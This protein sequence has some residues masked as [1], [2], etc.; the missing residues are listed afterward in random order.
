MIRQAIQYSSIVNIFGDDGTQI[1]S[2]T[3]GSG[4][5][6]GYSRDFL[7]IR[8]GDMIVTKDAN[9]HQLGSLVIDRRYQIM[10]INESGF[11]ARD[12]SA[13]EV[14]DKYC[15]HQYHTSV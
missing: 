4:E 8:Y 2:V 13:L 3:I 1:G 12:G 6:L 7:V 15:N 10:G 14:Y 11:T 5:L 9:D